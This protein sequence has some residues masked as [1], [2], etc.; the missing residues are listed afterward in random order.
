MEYGSLIAFLVLVKCK[1]FKYFKVKMAYLKSFEKDLLTLIT[2][3]FYFSSNLCPELFR[4]LFK[5]FAKSDILLQDGL[6]F[7]ESLPFLIKKE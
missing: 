7:F 1:E 2:E 4:E 6:S 3:Q 5:F